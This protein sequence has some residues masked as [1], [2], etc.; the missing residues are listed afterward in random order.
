MD[1]TSNT[2]LLDKLSSIAPLAHNSRGGRNI[3]FGFL[4]SFLGV[5]ARE[6]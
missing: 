5:L 4:L 6:L 2:D 3:L 1:D